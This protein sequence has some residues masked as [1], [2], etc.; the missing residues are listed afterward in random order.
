MDTEKMTTGVLIKL[1]PDQK[2]KARAA[3][4]LVGMDLSHYIRMLVL[5]TSD[6]LLTLDPDPDT[7]DISGRE[8][9][10]TVW[11]SL[12]RRYYVKMDND[13]IL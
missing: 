5:K 7:F 9:F 10:L 11:R 3:A 8:K 2:A 6:V 13:E 12:V 1:T 4:D